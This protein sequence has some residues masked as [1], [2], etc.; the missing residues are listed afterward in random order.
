MA[1]TFP[2]SLLTVIVAAVVLTVSVVLVQFE[3][4]LGW[5]WGWG[6]GIKPSR[7]LRVGAETG[8]MVEGIA[9]RAIELWFT[10]GEAAV[11]GNIGDVLEESDPG[12]MVGGVRGG[13]THIDV[14]NSGLGVVD[15]DLQSPSLNGVKDLIEDI[16]YQ[17]IPIEEV[18]VFGNEAT[19]FA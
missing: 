3:L 7:E 17:V 15:S 14:E 6:L 18:I 19:D 2:S 11:M 5:G 4:Q 1:F 10:R 16:G 13:R 12:L 8:W 9:E